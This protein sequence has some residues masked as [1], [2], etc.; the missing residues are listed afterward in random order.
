MKGILHILKNTE[1][2]KQTLVNN[3][4]FERLGWLQGPG[5]SSGGCG[6]IQNHLSWENHCIK[7]IQHFKPASPAHLGKRSLSPKPCT[8]NGVTGL[9]AR[10]LGSPG[11]VPTWCL[12]LPF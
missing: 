2:K 7:G 4:H 6:R 9:K 12:H 1:G 10:S 11:D 5:D 3:F 8:L